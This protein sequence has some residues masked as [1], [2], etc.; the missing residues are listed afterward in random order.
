MVGWSVSFL[1]SPPI[2][3]LLRPCSQS[4]NGHF[5]W[6]QWTFDISASVESSLHFHSKTFSAKHPLV[7]KRT[8]Y[9]SRTLGRPMNSW[10]AFGAWATVVQ[11]HCTLSYQ[12]AI[13]VGLQNAIH[14]AQDSIRVIKKKLF[15]R[16]QVNSN[17]NFIIL[18]IKQWNS[19]ITGTNLQIQLPSLSQFAKAIIKNY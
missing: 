13:F 6:A 19:P 10:V 1:G 14:F 9:G 15:R 17:T 11:Q 18:Q 4:K 5:T 8:I 12:I 16:V 2:N 7:A 3:N